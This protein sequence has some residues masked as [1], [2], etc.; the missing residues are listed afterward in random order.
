MI[1]LP[2]VY[3]DADWRTVTRFCETRERLGLAF[4]LPDGQVVR[5]A[6]TADHARGIADGINQFVAN[7]PAHTGD[8]PSGVDPI[9]N[10]LSST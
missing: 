2:A 5:F 4:D 6:V 9:H 1:R 3:I 8:Q 10:S 7:L